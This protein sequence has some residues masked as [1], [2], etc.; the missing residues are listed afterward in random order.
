MSDSGGAVNEFDGPARNVVQAGR[1]E[2]LH[3]HGHSPEKPAAPGAR[4]L[5]PVATLVDRDEEFSRVRAF[6]GAERPAG[7]PAVVI[8]AG[9]PGIGRR[10]FAAKLAHDLVE[11]FPDGIL[12]HDFTSPGSRDVTGPGDLLGEFLARLEVPDEDVPVS[13]AGRLGLFRDLTAERRVLLLLANVQASFQ[14]EELVPASRHAAVLV[15][16]DQDLGRL[17]E[18]H[19]A[20]LVRLGPLIDDDSLRLLEHVVG[21]ARVDAER[22][23]ARTLIALC[24]GWPLV[25]RVAGGWL[26][27]GPGREVGAAVRRMSRKPGEELVVVSDAAYGALP[28]EARRAYRLL[29]RHPSVTTGGSAV[30]F[31][32]EAA[33][34]LLGMD[35]DEAADVLDVLRDWFLL[36]AHDGRFSFHDLVRRHAGRQPG[37]D[38][39][40]AA[41]RRCV[42]W[43][44]RGSAA[45]DRAVNPFRP[46][47]GAVYDTLDGAPFGTGQE[48]KRRGLAWLVTEHRNLCAAVYVSSDKGWDDLVVQLCE[49]QW[50]LQLS[51]RPYGALIPVLEKGLGSARALGEPAWVFRLGT[52]LG[53]GLSETG[54]K[55]R[56]L[57]VLGEALDAARRSGDPLN[58][59]SALEFT[60]KAHLLDGDHAEALSYFLQARDLEE[61]HDRPRGVA[62]NTHHIARAR[63]GLGEVDAAIDL[64]TEAFH[65]FSRVRDP[66]GD[67]DYDNQAK[68]S[69][70]SGKAY[71]RA[72]RP[73]AAKAALN[74]A[75]DLTRAEG[76]AYQEAQ[77]LEELALTDPGQR[78]AHLRAAA[79]A[80]ERVGSVHATRVRLM[81]DGG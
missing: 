77:I 12:F 68:V 3:V 32:L 7:N 46:T 78:D 30:T 22:E 34:A 50:G 66:A 58:E 9:L 61:Q 60:G 51:N 11:R 42:E 21:Q 76:R 35:A 55:E 43:Y 52:Q 17:V 20:E 62:I 63:L 59:A 45:A 72:G 41:E 16:T 36:D 71:R 24:G 39:A 80:Y 38:D 28:E 14:V 53:R 73:A 47:L 4:G 37:E 40:E 65:R 57:A 6:L 44:L 18:R 29:A 74:V 70:T 33:A 49:A 2:H 67:R 81:V 5:P 79:E 69:L 13:Y 31:R 26:K 64:L 15:T 25:L 27:R 1:V 10:A 8:I 56:A 54:H 75:L 48:A 19:D 23:A